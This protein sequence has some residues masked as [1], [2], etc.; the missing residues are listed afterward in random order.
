MKTRLFLLLWTFALTAFGGN[1]IPNGSFENWTTR[2]F[3]YPEHYYFTSNADSH[4][5]TTFNV[6]KTTIAYSGTYAL[7]LKTIDSSDEGLKFG[8]A[9]NGNAKDGGPQEW[10][11]GIPCNEKPTGITGYYKYNVASGD[12]AMIIVTFK[13]AGS[14]IGSY[15]FKLYGVHASYAIFDFDFA[16]TETPD[17]MIIGFSSSNAIM[18]TGL[19]GSELYIDDVSLK[20]VVSQPAQ[21]NGD[22]ESWNNISVESV[23]NWYV[24][25]NDDNSSCKKTTD[26]E[27]GTFAV[28]LTSYIGDEDG[29]PLARP[30]QLSNGYWDD[31][32]GRMSGGI[33]FTYTKDTLAFYYK[34]AP[35]DP[36]GKAEISLQFKQNG[37][38]FGY[39]NIELDASAN[40]QYVEL[41]FDLSYMSAP[42]SVIISI[43]SNRWS[44]TSV[45]NAGSVLKLDSLH[46]KATEDSQQPI[47]TEVVN[48]GF[49]DWNSIN[50]EYPENYPYNSNAESVSRNKPCA[51]LF[52]TN[53]AYHGNY[54]VK[55]VTTSSNDEVTFGNF[56]NANPNDDDPSTWAGGIPIS[57]KPIGIKGHFK[58]NV[59]AGDTALVIVTFSKAGHNIGSYFLPL[60][61]VHNTYTPFELTFSPALTETPDSMILGFAS[62]WA[63]KEVGLAG[64]ELFIDSVALTGVSAQPGLLNGDFETWA[65]VSVETPQNWNVQND[66]KIDACRKTSDAA[67]G[68][69]AVELETYLEEKDGV[70]RANPSHITK[71]YWND[72]TGKW[73][74]GIPYNSKQNILSFYYKYAP[75]QPTDS[76][77]IWLQ[78][79]RDG[80]Q[81][82]GYQNIYLKASNDYQK[83]EVPLNIPT[84]ILPPNEVI[85]GVLSN[86]WSDTL[87]SD[88]GSILKIDEI[89]FVEGQGGGDEPNNDVPEVV[90]N[91]SFEEWNSN[92]FEYPEHFIYNNNAENAFNNTSSNNITKTQ[93]AFHGSY[94]VK[95]LTTQTQ[96]GISFGY[97]LN[98]NPDGDDPS[99]W[100]GG[101]PINEKPTGIK[102]HFKYNVESGDT[103]MVLVSFRKSG[104]EI[105]SY[106]LPLSGVHNTY[107]PFE[108]TFSPALTVTPDTVILGF[109]SSWVLTQTGLANSELYIDSIAFTGVSTQ[110]AQLNG[111]LESWANGNMVTPKNWVIQTDEKSTFNKTDVASDGNYAIEL[112]T[113]LEKK[114][115]VFRASP[116]E[117]ANGYWN[118]N[119]HKWEGGMPFNS[120]MDTLCFSYKYVPAQPTDSAQV[121]LNYKMD[122]NNFGGDNMYL[123]ASNQYK[124]IK[125]PLSTNNFITPDEV[126]I[127]FQSNLWSD[128][129][130]SHVGSVLTI[131]HIYFKSSTI[132]T[133]IITTEKEK[134]ISLFPNPTNGVFRIQAL[135]QDI[136][137]LDIYNL[138][139]QK[140]ISI[141]Y[142]QIRSDT[143]IDLTGYPRGMYLIKISS[144]NK[145]DV[146]KL[147][148]K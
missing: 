139:G 10:T 114:D 113:Y 26:A 79:K 23:E 68:N 122:G 120:A 89:K 66:K 82:Y 94:A 97:L 44:D 67:V 39:R 90:P 118:D 109:T 4:N 91:G 28:E 43:L 138:S 25:G 100:T 87:T 9:V 119:S 142:D 56:L 46:F 111:D 17:S 34:Y 146:K 33:P 92:D 115:G 29:N 77:Q 52:K 73:D 145:T 62:S 81:G 129:L 42:D 144:G 85:I 107:T 140:V 128:T 78:F 137:R 11:G 13:K 30:T 60:S 75:K 19:P 121:W 105:G 71:G 123:I 35:A 24:D 88:A 27:N 3:D 116:G 36:L 32:K 31:N 76:A 51:N 6:T 110:P 136:E 104:N 8:Y 141:G 40:Y 20:G 18:Q 148:L 1:T 143:E 15:F 98:G 55:L 124:Q 63:I 74:G 22:F 69:F 59:E 38:L 103:A 57:E 54:A 95:L 45:S 50:Y 102:G 101:I 99:S 49:E 135:G 133:P 7:K 112:H 14:L 41:P 12:T 117:I 127:G 125:L 47:N 21:L 2:N 130:T 37:N 83:M 106:F 93:D 96:D 132:P 126:I 147:I 131:D 16:L 86:L 134:G 64:S 72:N 58:Y 61:G 65:N 48:G 80:Q 70:M 84:G 108:F 5:D 53:D